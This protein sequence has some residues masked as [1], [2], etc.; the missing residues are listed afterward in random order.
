L[1]AGRRIS[2]EPTFYANDTGGEWSHSHTYGIGIPSY[3]GALIASD[4]GG[5]VGV[6]VQNYD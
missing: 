6:S 3:Y 2:G 1:G 4:N 5:R